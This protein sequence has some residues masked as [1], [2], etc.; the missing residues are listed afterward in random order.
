MAK[1]ERQVGGVYFEGTRRDAMQANLELRTAVR[2]LERV[3]RFSAGSS[4]ELHE[5]ALAVEWPRY[6]GEGQSILVA[7]HTTDSVLDHSLFIEQRI[8]DA[9]CDGARA[10]GRERPRVDKENPDLRVHA[11][12]F[13]DRCTLLI[14]TS[15]E[16]LHKRGWRS[17]QGAAPLA[18]TLAAGLVLLSGWDRRSPLI[19]PFCGSGTLLIEAALI[20]DDVAPGLFGREFAFQ[21]LPDHEEGVWQG[22]VEA[23]RKRIRPA[24]KVPLVG[25]DWDPRACEGA[26]SHLS[27]AGLAGRIRFEVMD[28]RK[29]DLKVGWNGFLLSNPPYGERVGEEREL[30]GLYRALGERWRRLGQGYRVALFSGNPRLDS[31]LGIDFERRWALK[32]GSLDCELLVGWLA[33]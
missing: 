25:S 27:T 18:E 24:R 14:D 30:L 3:A 10:R 11:H 19:D 31:Q 15:G 7:A 33:G 32:N 21:R 29:A 16:S 20:A 1:V 28:A 8:K 9:I 17:F 2:V 22:M 6:L 26:R 4:D 13:R 5:G 12:L 23:A